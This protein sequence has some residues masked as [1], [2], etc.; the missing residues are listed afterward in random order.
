MMIVKRVGGAKSNKVICANKDCENYDTT[1]IKLFYPS[2][3]YCSLRC[4]LNDE[5]A[6]HNEKY[7]D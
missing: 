7:G 1:A 3:A 5:D 4:K 6:S 2:S